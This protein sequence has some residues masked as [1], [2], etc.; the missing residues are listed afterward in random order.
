MQRAH[1]KLLVRICLCCHSPRKGLYGQGDSKTSTTAVLGRL[2][3]ATSRQESPTAP[4]SD[5]M[6][7]SGRIAPRMKLVRRAS[8]DLSADV[9]AS[10]EGGLALTSTHL[11]SSLRLTPLS[12]KRSV[13]LS[14]H[15]YCSSSCT[16]YRALHRF[17]NLEA[18]TS[19]NSVVSK[20]SPSRCVCYAPPPPSFFDVFLSTVAWRMSAYYRLIGAFCVRLARPVLFMEVCIASDRYLICTSVV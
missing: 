15:T 7:S 1:S 14:Y 18:P 13:V 12:S 6:I 5:S 19:N 4:V 10:T 8:C 16:L 9:Q 17:W 2:A 20:V 3:F 11:G